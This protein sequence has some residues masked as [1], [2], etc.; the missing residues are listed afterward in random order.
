MDP[1]LPLIALTFAGAVALSVLYTHQ[2]LTAPARV[3]RRRIAPAPGG[4]LAVR[5]P[6]LNVRRSRIPF[7]DRLP[8][9]AEARMR[10][11]IELER[12]GV[13]LR[14]SEFL[15]LRLALASGVALAGASLLSGAVPTWTLFAGAVIL[16]AIGWR[17]PGIWLGWKR[18]SRLDA[19]EQQLPGALN[20]IA[21]SLRAG[22]GLLQA[23]EFSSAQIGAPLG[24]ELALTLR[25]IR[26]G[27]DSE[28]AF[29]TMARR[30]GSPDLD[31][32]VT[33]ILI[34]RNVGGNLSEILTNV[35]ETIT[36]REK[37]HREVKVLTSRQK[38]T[39]NLVAAMPV[40]VAIAFLSFNPE[41]ADLLL[42]STVG[43]ITLGVGI[44]F[45]IVGLYFIRR[46]ARIEV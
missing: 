12:S 14:V 46:L 37:L 1:L 40:V 45:E 29:G 24:P 42:N 41:L 2:W 9:S 22:T 10:M 32:A 6:L 43:R 8:L 34:Q 44:A 19:I 35:S 15:G 23:I 33:A 25:Q 11:E 38:L 18:N 31:I 36:Q 27:T 13:P 26:L 30:V 4:D 3:T 5:S 17:L 21:K 7:V 39:G 16:V 28:E 20:A